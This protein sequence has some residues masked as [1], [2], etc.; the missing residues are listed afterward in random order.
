MSQPPKVALLDSNTPFHKRMGSPGSQCRDVEPMATVLTAGST[1]RSPH[2]PLP[3]D[4]LRP[5]ESSSHDA[6][7]VVQKDGG[8]RVRMQ[9]SRSQQH[10]NQKPCAVSKMSFQ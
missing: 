5:K 6:D 10:V 2:T 9:H 7:V 1:K 8:H 3:H 4:A